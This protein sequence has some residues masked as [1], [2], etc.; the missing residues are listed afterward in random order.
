MAKKTT[1]NEN[2][3][4]NQV[5]VQAPQRRVYDVG[6]WRTAMRAADVGRAKYLYD[7]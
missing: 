3:V 2:L 6:D 4:I 5:V 1:K 7:R